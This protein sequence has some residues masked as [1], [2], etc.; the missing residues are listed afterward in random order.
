MK[1]MVWREIPPQKN[2][3]SLCTYSHPKEQTSQV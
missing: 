3:N 1:D 2:Q